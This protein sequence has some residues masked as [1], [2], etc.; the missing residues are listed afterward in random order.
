MQTKRDQLL[1]YNFAASRLR[2]A[3]MLGDA[4][5]PHTPTRRFTIG[6]IVGAT[7]AV[8]LLSVVGIVGYLRP[9]GNDK[10]RS[11]GQI[12]VQKDTGTR[13]LLVNGVLHPVANLASARLL[14]GATAKV[15][16]VSPKSLQ[17]APRGAMIG[18][19]GAPDSLPAPKQVTASRWLVC[20]TAAAGETTPTAGESL[21]TVLIGGANGSGLSSIKLTAV[22]A[23]SALAVTAPDGTNYLIWQGKRFRLPDQ[24]AL[25][26]LGFDRVPPIPVSAIWIDALPAAADLR[27]PKIAGRGTAALPLGSSATRVGQIFAAVDT[28]GAREFFVMLADGLMPLNSVEAALLLADPSSAAA[29]EHGAVSALTI[30]PDQAIAVAHS[31]QSLDWSGLPSSLPTALG[32]TDSTE[33]CVQLDMAAGT[34]ARTQLVTVNRGPLPPRGS[35][36][37]SNDNFVVAP[38]HGA[39]VVG[40][41]APGIGI[42]AS[43][44][45]DDTGTRYPVADAALALLGYAGP[46]PQRVPAAL[47]AQ[48]PV[49]PVLAVQN[50]RLIPTDKNNS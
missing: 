26:A 7:V 42:G 19:E 38:T 18:I 49:G 39:I 37:P 36:N 25:V 32:A 1:A 35:S 21:T 24:S 46:A 10:W 2:S 41:A 28:A 5:A 45:I 4:D 20:A 27:A 11:P 16:R 47:L 34:D 9:P 30:S 14:V 3:V 33:P 44:L 29:Y 40:S 23:R 17:S 13:F 12:I 48:L 6:M 31:R 22:D 15:T 50:V 43:S 8:L